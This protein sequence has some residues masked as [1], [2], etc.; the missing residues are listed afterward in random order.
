M[1]VIKFLSIVIFTFAFTLLGLGVVTWWIERGQKRM[2]GVGMVGSALLIAVSY[3]FLGSRFSIAVFGRL[4]I[5]VDLPSLMVTAITYTIGVLMGFVLAGGI[6]LWMSGQ[7]LKPSPRSQR[8]VM[9]LGLTLLI[10][11]IISLI[12]VRISH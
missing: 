1:M 8:I 6:F 3:A 10:A 4:I 11:L 12:A 2:L 9:L 7:M 5:S